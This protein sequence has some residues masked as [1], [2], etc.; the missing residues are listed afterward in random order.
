MVGP[1]GCNPDVKL[2][3]KPTKYLR[4][5]YFDSLVFS[6]EAIRHLVAQLGSSQIVLGSDNPYPWQ[7]YSVRSHHRLHFAQ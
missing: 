7:L 4:Q 1:T 3:K 2:A 6:P 5:L